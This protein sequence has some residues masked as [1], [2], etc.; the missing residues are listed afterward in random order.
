MTEGK[1][2]A[3]FSE[4]VGSLMDRDY[5]SGLVAGYYGLECPCNLNAR[6]MEGFI[7]GEGL[8][9]LLLSLDGKADDDQVNASI[10]QML[11]PEETE[12]VPCA[13]FKGAD[14]SLGQ[15]AWPD[16]FVVGEAITT[17]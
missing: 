10:V 9:Q 12:R 8:R 7:A 2:L 4:A 14:W 13:V 17:I 15:R 16:P 3:M 1:L 5:L 6:C 11:F